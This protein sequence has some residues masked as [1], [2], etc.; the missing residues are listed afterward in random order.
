MKTTIHIPHIAL[1]KYIEAFVVLE[2]S[3]REVIKDFYPTNF[4]I[5]CFDITKKHFRVDDTAIHFSE[6][7]DSAPLSFVGV[8]D[9]YFFVKSTPEKTIQVIFKPYGAFRFLEEEMSEFTNLGTDARFILPDIKDTI[10]RMEDLYESETDC[11][12]LLES[13]FLERVRK[14]NFQTDTALDKI[15]FACNEIKKNSGDIRIKELCRK[16][17]MSETR[18]RVHFSKKV[19]ISPKT[20]CRIE[21]LNKI[22]KVLLEKDGTDWIDLCEAFN[23][24]DQ[25]HFIHS[26]KTH[27]GCTPTQFIKKTKQ[28]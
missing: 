28:L 4:T 12:K 9:H 3:E 16:I 5:M 10:A 15:S 17:N 14:D 1:Q 21:K 27:F 24:F 26:F 11:I 13:Y 18:F 6:V 22:N 7:S 2:I 19:G 20:F 23:F 8:V 25:A